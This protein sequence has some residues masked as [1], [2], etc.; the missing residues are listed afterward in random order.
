MGLNTPFAIHRYSPQVHDDVEHSD[1][2]LGV[3]RWKF[4][5]TFKEPPHAE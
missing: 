4:N 3:V 1:H 2:W 5:G